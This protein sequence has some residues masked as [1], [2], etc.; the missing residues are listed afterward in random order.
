VET[1]KSGTKGGGDAQVQKRKLLWANKSKSEAE[2]AA[3]WSGA[4][5]SQ[6][7]DGR[8]ANKFMRLMGIKEPGTLDSTSDNTKLTNFTSRLS[9]LFTSTFS[10]DFIGNI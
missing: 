3:K 10:T 4:R 2:E 1:F 9:T 5:F 6:D 8:Q 7:S